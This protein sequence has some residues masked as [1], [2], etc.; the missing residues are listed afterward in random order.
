MGST[1]R[2]GQQ[3]PATQWMHATC[4]FSVD[5]ATAA[6]LN[7]YP[8]L[9][10]PLKKDLDALL[11]K[12]GKAASSSS[13]AAASPSAAAPTHH[14]PNLTH[15]SRVMIEGLKVR[16]KTLN[17]KSLSLKPQTSLAVS[18]ETR[19]ERARG[20]HTGRMRSREWKVTCDT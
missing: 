14:N 17:N 1:E 12:A 9:P 2:N 6:E 3:F 15:G 13:A 19:D 20:R 16:A 11:K 7:G 18:G 4:F 5:S 8:A 10:S